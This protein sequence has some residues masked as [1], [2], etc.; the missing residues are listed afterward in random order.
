M[1][2][3]RL[4]CGCIASILMPVLGL[5]GAFTLSN[6][7]HFENPEVSAIGVKIDHAVGTGLKTLTGGYLGDQPP[8]QISADF[9]PDG[10]YLVYVAEVMNVTRVSATGS[11]P[12]QRFG[13]FRLGLRMI[14]VASGRQLLGENEFPLGS[15]RAEV[16]ALDNTHAW[17]YSQASSGSY[18]LLLF[19]LK[20]RKM[21]FHGEDFKRLNPETP[22]F[23]ENCGSNSKFF[24]PP[25]KKKG[26]VVEGTDGQRYLISQKT[27]KASLTK[28]QT[29]AINL[30]EPAHS[31]RTK[32]SVVGFSQTSGSRRHIQATTDAAEKRESTA[33]FIAPK[34]FIDPVTS[35]ESSIQQIPLRQ[36]DHIFVLS[37]VSTQDS[38]QK[39]LTMLNATTL[40]EVWNRRI[41]AQ[42]SMT[43]VPS[44]DRELARL[45][46]SKMFVVNN[47]WLVELST[48]TGKITQ[49]THL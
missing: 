19:N 45:Q 25:P 22:I 26:I 40:K 39:E 10:K 42:E 15:M 47:N 44:Y 38:L 7:A 21:V 29:E 27:G 41:P 46:G 35:D 5:V 33:D 3:S 9:T 1:R 11:M 37:S 6:L 13:Q 28:V 12:A 49:K 24:A 31:S 8:Y 17:L 14:E 48:K 4:G 32:D 30:L 18:R 23:P 43:F 34:F 2:K 16:V 20:T 36:K